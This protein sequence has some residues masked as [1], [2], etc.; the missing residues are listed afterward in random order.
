[1]KDSIIE[2]IRKLVDEAVPPFPKQA[3]IGDHAKKTS[4]DIKIGLLKST[5]ITRLKFTQP[6]LKSARWTI[7][8]PQ[9]PEHG[10]YSTNA[11]MVLAKIAKTKPR[12]LAVK[13]VETIQNQD[14]ENLL[15]KVD[16]AGPGFINFKIQK[17]AWQL[18]LK[19]FSDLKSLIPQIGKGKK[20]NVEF[21][22]ANPTGPL[23]IGNARG[24]PL[25]DVIASLLQRVGSKVTRTFY[26]NNIGGQVD[27]LGTSLL[28]WVKVHKNIPS[29]L[30]KEGYFGEYVQELARQA[31]QDLSIPDS[32]KDES[33][34][35]QELSQYG[36]KKLNDEIRDDCKAMGI[37][38]DEWVYES[39][40]RK[41]GKLDKVLERL[42]K[43]NVT[44]EAEGALW[45]APQDDYMQDRESVLIRNNG[46]PT[47][48]AN[49]IVCHEERFK[50]GF[51][52]IIDVWGSNHHGHVPRVKAALQALGHE[53]ESLEAV[54]YQYVRVVQGKEVV[55]M[56]KRAGDFIIASE[57][58]KEVGKDAFRFFLLM[59]AASAHLDFDVELARKHTQENPVYYVQYA[60]ARICSILRKATLKPKS[61]D[62]SLLDLDEELYLI[63]V[64]NDYPATVLEAARIREPHR[65]VFYLLELARHFQS[66]YS[67]A[68]GDPRYRV[69]GDDVDRTQAKLY[70]VD[71][72][73]EVISD[74]LNLLGISA[75]EEMRAEELNNG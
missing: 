64:L 75:P 71:I 12:D 42:K 31:V 57:V 37:E 29:D 20:V 52:T 47:Y 18:S 1:M 23:H 63:K 60:H 68:K 28:H 24:G 25:G 43:K 17:K 27:R 4:Q 32:I 26:S 61:K 62:L 65:I 74:G 48:F 44:R 53:P 72:I 41:K 66:Y 56:S 7:E 11:A 13:I 46:E 10:D 58:L 3:D 5:G 49:D 9:N 67:K 73:K 45:F 35:A 59:R 38:F 39:D 34:L 16:I 6:D 50:N 55:K 19:N 30:P 22:S 51:D 70:L 15:E 8:K 36:V 2:N 14:K 69:L 21:I 40:F 54:L 33:Q